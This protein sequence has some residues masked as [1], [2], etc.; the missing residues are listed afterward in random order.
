MQH[1]G[2]TWPPSRATNRRRMARSAI[3]ARGYSILEIAL[4]IPVVGLLM[5]IGGNNLRQAA[6]REEIDGIVR[7]MT[8]DIAAGRQAA[9]TRRTTVAVTMTGSLENGAPAHASPTLAG[10]IYT[11]GVSGGGTLRQQTLPS[12]VS[13]TTTCPAGSCSFDRRGMPTS[14]GTIT[15]TSSTTGRT[16]TITIESGTGRVSYSEP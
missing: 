14:A 2:A 5:A 3:G 6:A 12:G 13:M 1:I 16:Y 8:Y 7:S 9:L 4:V 10:T 15:V 11:I